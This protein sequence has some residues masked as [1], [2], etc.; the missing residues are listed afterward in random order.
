MLPS[1]YFLKTI[2]PLEASFI[3]IT[4]LLFIFSCNYSQHPFPPYS[5]AVSIKMN[6][7]LFAPALLLAYI[8]SQGMFGTIKQLSICA[9]IQ[10]NIFTWFDWLNH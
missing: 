5:L 1:I 7:L 6:I 4:F 8:A 9:G 2:G 3:G 10:V